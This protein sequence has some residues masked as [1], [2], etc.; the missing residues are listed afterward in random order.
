LRKFFKKTLKRRFCVCSLC[1]DPATA[2]LPGT[3]DDWNMAV[4]TVVCVS[5]PC[6]LLVEFI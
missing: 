4:K 6:A 2:G 5:V 3:L 1:T